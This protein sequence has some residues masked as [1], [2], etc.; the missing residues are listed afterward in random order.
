MLPFPYDLGE[1]DMVANLLKNDG[2]F[3]SVMAYLF[4]ND[5]DN[6]SIT[7]ILKLCTNIMYLI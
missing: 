2:I 7:S 6:I 4:K 5:A 3:K 1:H